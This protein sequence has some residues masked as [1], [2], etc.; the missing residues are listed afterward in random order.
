MTQGAVASDHEDHGVA[1]LAGEVNSMGLTKSRGSLSA[2]QQ[3]SLGSGKKKSQSLGAPL[4]SNPPPSLV[5]SF[6]A[7]ALGRQWSDLLLESSQAVRSCSQE[8]ATLPWVALFLSQ[9]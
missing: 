9:R 6:S 5:Q 1:R 2:S 8:E 7:P 3:L 4:G